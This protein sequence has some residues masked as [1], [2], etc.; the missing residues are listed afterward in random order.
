[1]NLVVVGAQWGDEGKGKIVDFLAEDADLIVRFSGGANAGHTIVT[2]DITYK[3]HLVPSGI[4]YPDKRVVLGTGMVIDPAALFEELKTIE[5]QGIDWKGRIF[6]SDRAHLVLP[7]YRK[8][9]IE[10]DKNRIKPIGT[11]G[12]GI[13]VTYAHKAHRDGIRVCDIINDKKFNSLPEDDKEYLKAYRQELSLMAVELCS[14]MAENKNKR[15]LFEGAQGVLLDLDVGTYPFVSSGY[16][17]AAGAAMGGGIGPRAING[18]LGVFKAYSTRVGNGP[19]PSEFKTDTDEALENYIRETGREYGVTTGRPRR[20]GY[21]D[22]PAL[23]YACRVNSLDS[24]I[25]T[26]LDVFDELQ[27]IKVCVAYEYEGRLIEDFLSDATILE[28]A[29]PVT[30]SFKAWNCSIKDVKKF[31]DLPNA[32]KNYIKFIEDYTQTPIDIISV[33]YKREETISRKRFLEK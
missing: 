6:L 18:V 33:G 7:K 13:G 15:I 2:G 5:K 29:T 19:F 1:M 8:E 21:L 25:L 9:D 16:S 3:L 14:F 24:L 31:D 11:T 22:L 30:K 27:E 20:C 32:A 17:Q 10:L 28:R 26:H 12:R 23:R 4:I